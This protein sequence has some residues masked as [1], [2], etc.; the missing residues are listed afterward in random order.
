MGVTLTAFDTH[1]EAQQQKIERD[2]AAHSRRFYSFLSRPP[3]P[4]P[5][6]FQFLMFN[7]TRNTIRQRG[8]VA[9]MDHAYFA[10]KGW[11]EA[12]YY[13]PT[14]IGLWKR[15]VGSVLVRMTPVI[16]KMIG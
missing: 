9:S 4:E 7:V 6:L 15:A 1:T 12:E 3:Y 11:L 8:N 2:L 14:R 13:Y 10:E 16:R 5:T